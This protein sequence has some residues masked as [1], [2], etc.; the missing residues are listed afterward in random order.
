[1]Q[2]A[3]ESG[4]TAVYWNRRYEPKII[5]RD[6]NVE[7]SLR[8]A[9]LAANNFSSAL[10]FEPGTIKNKS[11]KPFQVFTPFWKTCLKNQAIAK[12]ISAPKA[13]GTTANFPTSLPLDTLQLEPAL[14]WAQGFSVKWLPGEQKALAAL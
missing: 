4:A 11:G 9:G 6:A 10:L 7:T 8:Q 2:L 14:P 13:I 1:Q 3:K 5:Q 12:P